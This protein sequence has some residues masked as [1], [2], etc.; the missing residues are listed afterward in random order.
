[1]SV[2]KKNIIIGRFIPLMFA[3]IY[4]SNQKVHRL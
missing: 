2:E 4:L 3:S 1:M